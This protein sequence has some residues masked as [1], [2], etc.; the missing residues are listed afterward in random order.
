MYF[1]S[2]IVQWQ[3]CY[4]CGVS[5]VQFTHLSGGCWTILWSLHLFGKNAWKIKLEGIV[6]LPDIYCTWMVSHRLWMFV[7]IFPSWTTLQLIHMLKPGEAITFNNRRI[8]HG[9]TSIELNGGVRHLE[10]VVCYW[11]IQ[12]V[13]KFEVNRLYPRYIQWPDMG[14]INV[15]LPN[16]N[17]LYPR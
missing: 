12:A 9:R 14:S 3:L 10:V 1:G 17:S 15:H 16:R 8:L 4:M 5:F 7:T 13:L 6:P 11:H 2:H